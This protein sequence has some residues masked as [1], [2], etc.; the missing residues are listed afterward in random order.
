MADFQGPVRRALAEDRAHD[1]VT[2]QLLKTRG[3]AEG[4]F[5]AEE[6]IVVCGVPAIAAAVAEL[7]PHRDRGRV[8]A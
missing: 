1:D 4:R 8:R 5:V 2:T 3:A 7:D 6:R